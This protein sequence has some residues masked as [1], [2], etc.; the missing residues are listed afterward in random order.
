[1]KTALILLLF[2]AASFSAASFG[3]RFQPGEWYEALAKPA[4]TPPNWIFGP[5][6]TVLYVTISV[7]GWLVWKQ[8]GFAAASIEF[9]AYGVQLVLNAVWSW[10][11]FGLH[12]PGIAFADILLLCLGIAV[13]IVLFWRIT[14]LAGAL[15]L[16]YLGWVTF[17]SFLNWKLWR[18]NV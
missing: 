6:W 4:L 9:S 15:L 10:I 7:S 1:M 2:F 3:I 5:V 17:A 18:L 13:T 16:P 11:F 8:V 12:E 14:W